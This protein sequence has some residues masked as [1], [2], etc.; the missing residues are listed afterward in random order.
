[1]PMTLRVEGRSP[2]RCASAERHIA[3]SQHSELVFVLRQTAAILRE[4]VAQ[5]AEFQIGRKNA[6]RIVETVDGCGRRSIGAKIEI[7][8]SADRQ[9]HG[10]V[11]LTEMPV[12]R[13][14]IAVVEDTS[15]IGR[16][17]E[18]NSLLVGRIALNRNVAA[19]VLDDL[20][21]DVTGA[22]EGIR[23]DVAVA[24]GIGD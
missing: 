1:M 3:G 8:G 12:Q 11:I 21:E 5:R 16:T 24:I 9:H 14:R 20:G 4:T 18:I 17:G 22:V 23:G 10:L 7:A 15:H 13:L 2:G 6:D 19:A